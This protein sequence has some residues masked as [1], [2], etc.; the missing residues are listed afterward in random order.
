V[1]SDKDHIYTLRRLPYSVWWCG[2]SEEM[3]NVAPVLLMLSLG[4][5][6]VRAGHRHWRRWWKL[7][8]C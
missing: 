2:W 1:S 3:W 7:Q 8:L 6:L 4:S 5:L